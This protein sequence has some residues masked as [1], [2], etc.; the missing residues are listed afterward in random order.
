MKSYKNKQSEVKYSLVSRKW[1]CCLNHIIVLTSL[2][3]A[4]DA[5]TCYLENDKR[6][7]ISKVFL[8]DNTGNQ[9]LVN[10]RP[11]SKAS[12][13]L[14][15]LENIKFHAEWPIS[16]TRRS[17]LQHML[18]RHVDYC[19]RPETWSLTNN[20]NGNGV[21]WINICLNVHSIIPQITPRSFLLPCVIWFHLQAG[22]FIFPGVFMC[23]AISTKLNE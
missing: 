17:C 10:V 12:L 6:N 15:L 3:S 18:P 2:S 20:P 7:P 4:L 1:L 8:P 23:L 14:S 9:V 13:R 19:Y 21:S 5:L 11:R 22:H 16:F